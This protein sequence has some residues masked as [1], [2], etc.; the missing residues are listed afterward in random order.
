MTTGE[1]V[2]TEGS[3]TVSRFRSWF[4]RPPRAHGEIETER[5][6]SFLEL[7]S[8][9]VYVV[10]ISQAASHLAGHLSLR[11][12]LE[13]VVIFGVVWI[14]WANGTLYYELHGREDGRTRTFVFVQMAI[15]ALLAVFTGNAAGQTGSA[16][17]L[18][19]AGFL[20]VMTWLWYTV[21]RQ[22]RPE[23][24]AITARYLAAMVVSL[25][26]IAASVVLPTDARL[27]A[28][29]GFVIGW[30]AVML[31]FGW[32]S[33]RRLS[34][35]IVPTDS[36]VERFDL[37]VII[38][39]GEVVVGVVNG[40]SGSDMDPVTLGT[41]FAALMVGFG[42]WWIFFDFAGRR[43]PRADGLAVNAWMGGHLPVA[44]AIAGAG[45]AMVGLI[46]H[47]HDAQAPASTAWL[48]TG[49]VAIALLALGLLTRSLA[50]YERHAAVYRPLTVVMVGAAI[51]A[52][53]VG[54]W[55]PAPWLLALAMAAILAVVW[56]FAVIRV[57]QSGAWPAPGGTKT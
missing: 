22:D 18:V 36:M 10:V 57:L 35:G 20:V 41:G 14:A 54:G 31:Y 47:A 15:L 53:L 23:Y 6:V 25:V 30:L 27:V 17:A 43:E 33:R 46:Q 38:V 37:L 44:L 34:T 45:A 32:D 5:R 21:R 50:D 28:W 8:D 12:Y 51:V 42:L 29:A 56:V 2:E 40:L 4:W 16:F 49:S 7:F 48:L 19:Y 52:L 3:S 24:M 55:Q 1:A 13:F 39:L 9:L 26:V 11:A